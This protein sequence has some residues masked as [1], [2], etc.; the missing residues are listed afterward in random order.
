[1][2]IVAILFYFL[3]SAYGAHALELSQETGFEPLVALSFYDGAPP[4]G[5]V[6][7]AWEVVD[8]PTVEGYRVHVGLDAGHYIFHGNIGN[9]TS[10]RMPLPRGFI[11]HIAVT[12]YNAAGESPYSEEVVTTLPLF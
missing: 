11:W 9:V 4:P 12:A 10:F 5:S 6:V 1:M 7:L 8:D 3:F 2:V